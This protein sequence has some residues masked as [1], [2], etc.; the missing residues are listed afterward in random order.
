VG[1]RPGSSA[2]AMRCASSGRSIAAWSVGSRHPGTAP[3]VGRATAATRAGGRTCRTMPRRTWA[4]R[5]STSTPV[6]RRDPCRT[7]TEPRPAR[8]SLPTTTARRSGRRGTAPRTRA[9]PDGPSRPR[10]CAVAGPAA[11]GRRVPRR[12]YVSL[13]RR[14]RT[15]DLRQL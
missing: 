1:N 13:P 11:S 9:G 14:Y 4:G 3:R 8:R 15:A 2:S 12:A 6:P 7:R 5:P 10:S